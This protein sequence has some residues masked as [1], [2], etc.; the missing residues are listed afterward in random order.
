M[1]EADPRHRLAVD[2]VVLDS[3]VMEYMTSEGLVD[4][5]ASNSTPQVTDI[6]QRHH[7]AEACSI[8][9][10]VSC[11]SPG[12]PST[13]VNSTFPNLQKHLLAAR[14]RL[15]LSM[16]SRTACGLICASV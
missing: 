13:T 6:L 11:K 15:K 3:M 1:N 14:K 4:S 7:Y 10:L 9:V 12:T 8:C 16:W 5:L 2:T